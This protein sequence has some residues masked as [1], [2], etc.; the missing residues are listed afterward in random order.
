MPD[1]LSVGVL[2]IRGYGSGAVRTHLPV[3]LNL[4]AQAAPWMR[5]RDVDL[6]SAD[7]EVVVLL[8]QRNNQV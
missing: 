6:P 1:D 5:T 7:L 4:D 2:D 3:K 8:S